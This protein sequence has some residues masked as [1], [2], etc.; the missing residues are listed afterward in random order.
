MGA[1]DVSTASNGCL[2]QM[3]KGWRKLFGR[4]SEVGLIKDS[5]QLC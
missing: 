3:G 4:F 2:K 1:Q 5:A